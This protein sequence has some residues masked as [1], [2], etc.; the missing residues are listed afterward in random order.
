MSF[1]HNEVKLAPHRP[2]KAEALAHPAGGVPGEPLSWLAP[3]TPGSQGALV[4][5]SAR[6]HPGVTL[7]ASRSQHF[8][9]LLQ[10]CHLPPLSGGDLAYFTEKMLRALRENFSLLSCLGFLLHQTLSNPPLPF[11]V[12]SFPAAAAPT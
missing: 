4:S 9:A 8:A 5:A 1:Y 12:P 3:C 6:L 7:L 11:R 10:A 2:G